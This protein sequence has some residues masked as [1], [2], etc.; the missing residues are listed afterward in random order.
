MLECDTVGPGTGRRLYVLD[1]EN[2]QGNCDGHVTESEVARIRDEVTRTVPTTDLDQVVI[3]TSCPK[4]LLAASVWKGARQVF[5]G[6]HDGADL[7]LLDVLDG[8]NIAA[9]FSSV[10]LG[11]G[12]HIFA[13]SAKRLRALGC[14]VLLLDTG[15]PISRRLKNAVDGIIHVR[16]TLTRTVRTDT[17]DAKG[18]NTNRKGND[19]EG[20]RFSTQD[21]AELAGVRLSTV[22]NWKNRSDTFPK[23]VGKRDGVAVFDYGEVIAWMRAN[24]KKIVA[25]KGQV[26]LWAVKDGIRTA[27]A[28]DDYAVDVAM[29]FGLRKAATIY[30]LENLWKELATDPSEEHLTE[31]VGQL[32]ERDEAE[33]VPRLP[34]LVREVRKHMPRIAKIIRETFSSVMEIDEKDLPDLLD[35]AIG[36]N[37]RERGTVRSDLVDFSDFG[38]ADEAVSFALELADN[39][40]HVDVYDPACG[41]EL[42]GLDFA[43]KHPNLSL[44]LSDINPTAAMLAE[45]RF[46][47]M[48]GDSINAQV[49]T[50]DSLVEDGHPG[51]R[52]DLVLLQP[53]YRLH[54]R[55]TGNVPANDPRWTY[56]Q[57]M[58]TSPELMFLQDAIHHLKPNGVI[59]MTC[60]ERES[61]AVNHNEGKVRR[62]LVAEGRVKA[63]VTLR[64]DQY[65]SPIRVI[66]NLWVVG[67]PDPNLASVY[68]ID[69]RNPSDDRIDMGKLPGWLSRPLE[70]IWEDG[71]Y[72]WSNVP[73]RDILADDAARLTPS[74]WIKNADEDPKII[75]R[76]MTSRAS[77][78]HDL[79]DSLESGRSILESIPSGMPD[80]E[81]ARIINVGEL[82]AQGG[83]ELH[84]GTELLRH[85]YGQPDDIVT[86]DDLQKGI[87]DTGSNGS[88]D[89]GGFRTK[90]GDILFTDISPVYAVV[91]ERGGHRISHG[92]CALT[93]TGDE[94][95]PHFAAACLQAKWN[96]RNGS[97]IG[98][99]LKVSPSSMELPLVDRVTQDRYLAILSAR[100]EVRR[101]DETVSSYLETLGNAIRFG[102]E[103]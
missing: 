99:A 52:A 17:N 65:R 69:G 74:H 82:V 11:S 9:R 27:V 8:E 6:G 21:I 68:M 45:I 58:G 38:L 87:S 91:D 81:I 7:A 25:D 93:L 16:R 59:L 19:M 32:Q 86:R 35:A 92:I 103:S 96:L 15:T 20:M 57:A 30:G 39:D 5:H 29:L 47:L 78:I 40:S 28:S 101:L 22:S 94:W 54:P 31:Y 18:Q 61:F 60:L 75:A 102:A 67:D 77:A 42:T 4:N 36:R 83:A 95:D 53:P 64:S 56:S 90:A 12:D 84:R 14:G 97:P 2:M 1:I 48:Y 46:L 3:G 66:S 63:V 85:V 50:V 41:L 71:S 49:R 51:V 43:R 70:R 62:Q 37:S 13:P 55:D 34:N 44:F 73:I 33:P 88:S 80:F 76:E 89:E 98:P 23:P 10:L 100:N 24:N 26:L 72:R 79:M